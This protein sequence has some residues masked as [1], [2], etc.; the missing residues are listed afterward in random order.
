MIIKKGQGYI[1][2]IFILILAFGILFFSQN[3]FTGNVVSIVSAQ[4]DNVQV[5]KLSVSGLNYILSPSTFKKGIPVKI[6]TDIANMPG[7]SK[8]V[9]ISAFNVMKGVSSSDN[10]IE[11]MPDKTG[12]FNIA[13]SMNMY[14]ATF[15]VVDDSGKAANYVQP[16]SASA[17][18]CGMGAGCGCG[19]MR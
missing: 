18:S 13:C 14:H 15:N 4:G 10:I 12:T 7:C 2:G 3:S 1:A 9:V 6:E 19:G 5:A 11:F 16:Q 8:S 17:G